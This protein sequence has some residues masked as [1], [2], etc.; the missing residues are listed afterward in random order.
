MQ[1]Q[2]RTD[3]PGSQGWD[4]STRNE[5]AIHAPLLCCTKPGHPRGMQ[6]ASLKTLLREQGKG[7]RSGV[8]GIVWGQGKRHFGQPVLGRG[9]VTSWEVTDQVLMA[10]GG[11]HLKPGRTP[12]SSL[13]ENQVL[14]AFSM[15]VVD[16]SVG[17]SQLISRSTDVYV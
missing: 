10:S 16:L 5:G 7:W 12:L 17:S 11:Q 8:T 2:S 13:R 9:R 1:D 6:S 4:P 14:L 3:N 15:S